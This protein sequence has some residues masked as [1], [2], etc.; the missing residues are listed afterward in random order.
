[1]PVSADSAPP[2]GPVPWVAMYH[3]VGDDSNDPYRVTV[4][5][6]RLDRQLRWL[7]GRGLTGVS[8]SDLLAARARGEGRKL[9]GLTFDDG[10]ADF[11]DHALPVLRRYGFGA[12]LF[13]LPGLPAGTTTG[14]GWVRAR[15]CSP[16]TASGR[17]R[18]RESRSART[19]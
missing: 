14:T 12:T 13:A 2:R 5:P 15:R 9:V 16:R 17:R 3:S 6:E 19:G 18:P 8:V 7:R 1:M 11:V 10:Y 4:T